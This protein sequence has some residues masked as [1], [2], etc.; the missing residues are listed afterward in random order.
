MPR[1]VDSRTRDERIMG[2][3]VFYAEFIAR[4]KRREAMETEPYEAPDSVLVKYED[5][6]MFDSVKKLETNVEEM[7]DVVIRQTQDDEEFENQWQWDFT[8]EGIIVTSFECPS[9]SE[10]EEEEEEGQSDY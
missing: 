2:E 6:L 3:L 4:N 10:Q 5:I 1:R 7:L 8:D 9:D